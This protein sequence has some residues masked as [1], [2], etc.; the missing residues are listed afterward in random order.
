MIL[1]EIGRKRPGPRA[2][3]ASTSVS[4]DQTDQREISAAEE[5][6][7]G[8]FCQLDSDGCE[9]VKRLR[10]PSLSLPPCKHIVKIAVSEPNFLATRLAEAGIEPGL[11]VEIGA[12]LMRER[13]DPPECCKVCRAT[14][15]GARFRKSKTGQEERV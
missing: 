8:A 11:A 3:N 1:A 13:K 7:A 2:D 14:V 10:E 4:G 9:L 5:S 15:S 6:S 12:A